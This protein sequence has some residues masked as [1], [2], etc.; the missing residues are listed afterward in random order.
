[1][2]L[3]V[4]PERIEVL[5]STAPVTTDAN[6]RPALALA[7]RQ[8][9]LPG[10]A[11]QAV[12]ALDHAQRPGGSGGESIDITARDGNET[13]EK[14]PRIAASASAPAPAPAPAPVEA[15]TKDPTPIVPPAPP[16]VETSVALTAGPGAAR[17]AWAL[18]G[19]LLGLV[20]GYLARGLTS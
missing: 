7:A 2:R 20:L 3:A 8:R 4:P 6:E 12:R 1:M 11:K 19:L 17:M 15:A 10:V 5:E 13:T 9:P 14:A 18:F 16:P